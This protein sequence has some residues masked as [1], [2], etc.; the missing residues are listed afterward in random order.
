MR[1]AECKSLPG[2]VKLFLVQVCCWLAGLFPVHVAFTLLQSEW[3]FSTEWFIWSMVALVLSILAVAAI[4]G[5]CTR[6]RRAAG[7]AR[8]FCFAG[9]LA[10]VAAC[11]R[12]LVYLADSPGIYSN[13]YYS[14]LPSGAL[15]LVSIAACVP[16]LAAW[17]VYFGSGA[18]GSVFGRDVSGNRPLPPLG[19]GLLRVLCWTFIVTKVVL[20]LGFSLDAEAGT[21]DILWRLLAAAWPGI[22]F[23]AAILWLVGK[24]GARLGPLLGLMGGWVLLAA[25]SSSPALAQ[26]LFLI[27]APDHDSYF[28]FSTYSLIPVPL[29]VLGGFLAILA[30]RFVAVPEEAAWVAVPETVANAPGARLPLTSF[31]ILCLCFPAVSYAG[32]I[33]AGALSAVPQGRWFEAVLAVPAALCVGLGIALVHTRLFAGHPLGRRWEMVFFATGAVHAIAFLA[34]A[35][36][37]TLGAER[38][39]W[40]MWFILPRFDVFLGLC[41]FGLYACRRTGPAAF[42]AA[43][44][45]VGCFALFAACVAGAAALRELAGLWLR[46]FLDGTEVFSSWDTGAASRYLNSGFWLARF[47]C[48][49]AVL[50][51]IRKRIPSL[52]VLYAVCCVWLLG[53]FAERAVMLGN[54]VLGGGR[55]MWA[56]LISMQIDAPAIVLFLLY[57]AVS[58]ELALWREAG[59]AAPD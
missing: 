19:V 37:T 39:A 53:L 46:F 43:P 28:F 7:A 13:R 14:Q 56:S 29:A 6:S 26:Y 31:L 55:H 33:L 3:W 58:R 52:D 41:L 34:L 18:A 8:A 1:N 12:L 35:L 59:R 27:N 2:L 49:A 24:P 10:A 20:L 9:I 17:H 32:N 15:L 48:P 38:D 44:V 11:V 47:V 36:H 25:L 23:P 42:R 57:C 54:M 45:A 30:W 40:F 21:G 50:F 4:T 5:I 22:V 16:V 51:L